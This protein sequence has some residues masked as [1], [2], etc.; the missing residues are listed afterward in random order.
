MLLPFSLIYGVVAQLRR[1]VFDSG[2]C[3]RSKAAIP[4]LVVGNI[5]VGG[6]GKTPMVQYLAEELSKTLKVAILSRG[7]GRKTRG[8]MEV[9]AHLPAIETGD[10]PLLIKKNLPEILVFVGENRLAA[11]EQI[12]QQYPQTQLIIMDDGFQ[13]LPLKAEV[14]LLLNNYQKP[15]HQGFPF[16]SGTQREFI[17]NHIQAQLMAVTKVP[18]NFDIANAREFEKHYHFGQ[19][20]VFY[21][22]YS[23]ALSEQLSE[24]TPCIVVSGLARNAA[25]TGQLKQNYRLNIVG[26]F[27]YPDHHVYR[28]E[29]VAEWNHRAA[30]YQNCTLITTQKDQVKLEGLNKVFNGRTVTAIPT[31]QIKFVDKEQFFSVLLNLLKPYL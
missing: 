15:L 11:I 28:E 10:E 22:E 5:E 7:Y 13:H 20:P 4:T 26:E 30:R 31:P 21:F 6:T 27:Y 25:F 19:K 23:S 29:N 8:F 18:E 14:Y 24:S 16:P 1:F 3:K 9:E 17:F 2:I 12:K